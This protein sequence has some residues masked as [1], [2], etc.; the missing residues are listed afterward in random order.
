MG[1][2]I[3][4]ANA[5]NVSLRDVD[6]GYI[7]LTKNGIKARYATTYMNSMFNELGKSGTTASKALKQASGGKDFAQL[8]KSGKSVDQI[9]LMLQKSCK[10]TGTKFS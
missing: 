4:T 6:A 7:T 3:P 1:K 2:L 10:K 8:M 9:L 5:Y